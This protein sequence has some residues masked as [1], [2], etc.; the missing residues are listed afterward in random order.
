MVRCGKPPHLPF[1]V[2]INAAASVDWSS[3]V[4]SLEMFGFNL[5][6]L[7]NLMESTFLISHASSP[8]FSSSLRF[9]DARHKRCFR[10]KQKRNQ[11]NESI[12][13]YLYVAITP[14]RESLNTIRKRTLHHSVDRSASS[15]LE[16]ETL[17]VSFH[18]FPCFFAVPFWYADSM[19]LQWHSVVRLERN[20]SIRGRQAV[21]A[22]AAAT[23]RQPT[24]VRR[25]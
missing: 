3:S 17:A 6:G 12:E 22:A 15:V 10:S 23:G 16:A 9:C 19:E 21:A 20:V 4:L 1:R 8:S 25:S 18:F 5:V 7:H 13:F 24:A 14:Y 11:R 2:L